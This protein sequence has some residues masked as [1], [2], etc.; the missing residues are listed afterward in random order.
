MLLDLRNYSKLTSNG[1]EAVFKELFP[2]IRKILDEKDYKPV[3]SNTW[4]D[5]VLM[6]FNNVG[7]AAAV[8]LRIN[9]LLKTKIWEN[10]ELEELEARIAL[11]VGELEN[12]TDPIRELGQG[13]HHVFG[14]DLVITSRIEP[15][16]PP[17]NIY[18]TEQAKNLLDGEIQKN[19][20]LRKKTKFS[21]MGEPQLAKGF[22]ARKLWW[23]G[24][25][26]DLPPP[27]PDSAGVSEQH[28]LSTQTLLRLHAIR[29]I[30]DLLVSFHNW[31][32][33]CSDIK[34]LKKAFKDYHKRILLALRFHDTQQNQFEA[35]VLNL[36]KLV[37]GKRAFSIDNPST[38]DLGKKVLPKMYL[39]FDTS[40]Q[41]FSKPSVS[42][43]IAPY[44]I[45]ASKADFADVAVA[46]DVN[47]RP[48]TELWFRTKKSEG[49]GAYHKAETQPMYKAANPI[50][51][52]VP[53]TSILNVPIFSL[54][55]STPKPGEDV[56]KEYLGVLSIT[57][58][59][60]DAFSVQDFAWAELAASLIGSFYQ[61]FQSRTAN[62]PQPKGGVN[63][64]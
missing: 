18:V 36:N 20:N 10:K 22:P 54:T 60:K 53:Y 21:D 8:A 9:N 50:G 43:G 28:R 25:E 11:H 52:I 1:Q 23:F 34:Q 55:K 26:D 45:W 46:Y 6:V 3:D 41:T 63:V 42:D 33:S 58:V 51:N 40:K 35:D 2:E 16:V 59:K 62:I 56:E 32:Q 64:Q 29:A 17:K 4:G 38:N 15:I 37:N 14:S 27:K 5:S 7:S 61:S 12:G 30:N 57:S 39:D 48:Q 13:G 44:I 47:E 31:A 49:V 24:Q 19:K